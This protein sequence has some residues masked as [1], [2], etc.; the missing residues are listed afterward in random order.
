MKTAFPVLLLAGGDSTRFW[1]FTKKN[2]FPFLGKPFL[3]WHYE[4]L[5]RMGVERAIVVGNSETMEEIKRVVPPKSLDV[6]YVIQKGRGQVNALLSASAFLPDGPIVIMNASDVYDDLLVKELFQHMRSAD[7]V[8]VSAIRVGSYFPGG[9]MKLKENGEVTEIIEKPKPGTE[10]GDIVRLAA[11]GVPNAKKFADILKKY[12][13]KPDN[14]YES[15]LNTLLK[16]VSGQALVTDT[17]W[18][19]LKYPW[20]IL[21]V[22]D[23]C[24]GILDGQ[25]FG[26]NVTIGKHV[27]I[28]G[29]V[30]I[31]DHVTISEGTKI[32]GPVYIGSGTIIG[33]NNLIRKSHIGSSV[34]TG[35]ST[36]ITRS[37]IGS[38]SWF[39][40]NYVGDS[41][42]GS[43]VS[44]GSGTVLANL[45]LDESSIWSIVKAEKIDTNRNK[46]GAMIGSNV[47][48]GVNASIMPGVKIG[49]G[50]FVGAGVIL[51]T[52][53]AE[54]QY[55]HSTESVTIV[56]NTKVASQTRDEFRNKL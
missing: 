5:V 52:D 1:P 27:T 33:N 38:H 31:E 50:S 39:H 8:Y 9:Y 6:S 37:Y 28:D 11:D 16:S 43:N 41:V 20:H 36:D 42:I 29:P 24:L 4:Q 35:F 47:R 25:T 21:S 34:V 56:K 44:M 46:L 10:P 23:A 12:A 30:F 2:L 49:D 22:M 18:L 54:G 51:P 14:G 40:T 17:Q 15:G 53:L 48:I 13:K 7:S 19:T 45:R 3:L 55:C 32:V 26:K